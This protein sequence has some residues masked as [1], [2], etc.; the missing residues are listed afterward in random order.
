MVSIVLIEP[1]TAGNIGAVARVMQNFGMRTLI[2]IN[3]KC[4]YLSKEALDRATSGK[5]I[6]R[7]AKVAGKEIL[8]SFGLVAGTSARIG[9]DYNIRRTPVY[10]GELAQKIAGRKNTA[11]VFG[12]E[13]SG[14]TNKELSLCDF[15]ITIPTDRKNPALNISHAVAIV[16]YELCKPQAENALKERYPLI[17]L[18]EKK[19]L[20]KQIDACIDRMPFSTEEKRNTQRLVWRH[21]LG[22]AAVTKRE[23]YA[24]LGFFKKL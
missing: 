10:P 5:R 14:L 21:I 16:L 17:S 4:D 7:T 18:L 19:Q 24:L 15:C 13:S 12:R 23:A 20:V 1:E 11:I 22:K 9:T 6:L 2:L 8:D 3:P